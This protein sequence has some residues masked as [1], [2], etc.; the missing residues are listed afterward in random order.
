MKFTIQKSEKTGQYWFR[1]VASNGNILASSEQY[2]QKSSAVSAVESI[3]Q[4]AGDAEVV[5][6]T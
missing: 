3:K 1:I 2:A 4:R 5:D 6:E